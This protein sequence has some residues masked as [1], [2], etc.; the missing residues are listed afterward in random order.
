MASRWQPVYLNLQY[1]KYIYSLKYSLY[2]KN[3]TTVKRTTIKKNNNTVVFN[4]SLT[5]TSHL[6]KKRIYIYKGKLLRDLIISSYA[7]GY[8]LGEFTLTRKPFH[9]TPK[10]KK[11]K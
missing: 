1:I 4:K 3:F 9:Y 2:Q 7:V 5:I 10:L 11:K 6:I 8:K